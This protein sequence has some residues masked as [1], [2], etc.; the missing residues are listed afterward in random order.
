[1]DATASRLLDAHVEF[2][3][4]ELTGDRLE[5]SAASVVE[6]LFAVAATVRVD[7]VADPDEVKVVLRAAVHRLGESPVV[8]ELV[9]DVADAM[10]DLEASEDVL[11]GDLVDRD[12]IEALVEMVLGLKTA[13]ERALDRFTESPLVGVVATKFVT[14]LVT[15]FVQQ[16]R[17][18]A[19]RVP[20]VS[21]LFSI[22]QSAVSRMPGLAML[23]DA[24]GKG[25]Q[26]AIRRTNGTMRDAMKDAPLHGAAMELWDLHAA[27]P[28][29]N[30]REYLSRQE[31]RE[32]ALIV[33][34]VV[35]SARGSDFTDHVVDGCVDVFFE[36]YGT[37]D[38]ATLLDELGVQSADL[39]ADL[40]RLAPP[41][42]AAAMK[43]G[44]LARLVRARLEPFYAS[45]AVAAILTASR[46]KPAPRP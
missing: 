23:S 46:P 5:A 21:S 39:T 45:S 44:T 24:A 38:V 11:L 8:T 13:H 29:A 3:L 10:Y 42:V 17:E 31:L 25:A 34:D 6:D 12:P 36:R 7:E 15:E 2:V 33:H 14:T 28:L 40:A 41:I 35:Q 37:H 4:S 18:R 32:L 26:F 1:M 30:L 9:G 27:E 43:D 19:E 16:N 22:G 20:G